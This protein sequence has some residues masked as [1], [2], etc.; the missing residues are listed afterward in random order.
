MVPCPIAHHAWRL[1]HVELPREATHLLSTQT[2][3]KT[4]CED[5]CARFQISKPLHQYNE[6][7]TRPHLKLKDQYCLALWCPQTHGIRIRRARMKPL[8][9][10]NEGGTWPHLKLKDQYCLALWCP[11]TH[12]IRIRRVRMSHQCFKMSLKAQIP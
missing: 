11:Q 5:F 1:E 3:E 7:G 8:Q 10:Y 12:G 4:P 2:T 9:Q 6:G